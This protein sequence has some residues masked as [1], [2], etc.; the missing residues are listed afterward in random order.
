MLLSNFFPLCTA[1][2]AW[3]QARRASADT[4]SKKIV[5]P[6]WVYEIDCVRFFRAGAPDRFGAIISAKIIYCFRPGDGMG[7]AG[8]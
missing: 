7:S 6:V 8:K 3:R 2:F 5:G 4:I 1:A